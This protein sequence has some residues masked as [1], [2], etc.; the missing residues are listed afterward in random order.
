M[1]SHKARKPYT[2]PKRLVVQEDNGEFRTALFRERSGKLIERKSFA[3]KAEFNA[4]KNKLSANGQ[5]LNI[6]ELPT[7]WNKEWFKR[8]D[9][10]G[11][12]EDPDDIKDPV[13][14]LTRFIALCDESQHCPR[15]K[16]PLLLLGTFLSGYTA[17]IFCSADRM[18]NP[19][20]KARAV[21]LDVSWEEGI[22]DFLRDV[23]KSLSFNLSKHYKGNIPLKWNHRKIITAADAEGG[24]ADIAYPKWEREP[25]AQESRLLDLDFPSETVIGDLGLKMERFNDAVLI[26]QRTGLKTN[27][28]AQFLRK[29]PFCAAVV[30]RSPRAK[31]MIDGTLQLNP[32]ELIWA[33]TEFN[34]WDDLETLVHGFVAELFSKDTKLYFLDN[35]S[36]AE[37]LIA[38]YQAQKGVQRLTTVQRRT[39]RMLLAS[40]LAFLDYLHLGAD[41]LPRAEYAALRD[42]WLWRLLPGCIAGESAEKPPLA[43]R[44][45]IVEQ[46]YLDVFLAL[47]KHIKQSDG[48]IH[49][50]RVPK[51]ERLFELHDPDNPDI[52]IYGY[53]ADIY[54]RSAGQY[55]PCLVFRKQTL[56]VLMRSFMSEVVSVPLDA[57]RVL[58]YALKSE[59]AQK[60]ILRQ[61]DG[62][63]KLHMPAHLQDKGTT[64]A[65]AIKLDPA[66]YREPANSIE[67]LEIG[68]NPDGTESSYISYVFPD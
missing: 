25:T 30:L 40:L 35:W 53:Y 61:S 24:L 2:G 17:E 48:G 59:W 29:N 7:P 18:T 16:A 67:V 57:G 5:V 36:L 47:I 49:I 26:E 8:Y 56:L 22:T 4:Y 3:A 33:D 43:K 41:K 54:L 13:E 21:I 52:E 50:L 51:D 37:T 42:E 15:A 62:Y 20:S 19:N 31:L 65:V 39:W 60:N 27:D 58:R 45:V 68:R 28:I 46:D 32:K 63:F 66:D 44:P 9:L 23:A 11:W 34:R 1:A 55:F 14:L 6:L 64:Y 12:R 38:R 10:S